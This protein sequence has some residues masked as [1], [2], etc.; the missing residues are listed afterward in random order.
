MSIIGDYRVR[1]YY[2]CGGLVCVMMLRYVITVWVSVHYSE[3]DKTVLM[4]LSAVHCHSN[5]DSKFKVY[6]RLGVRGLLHEGKCPKNVN[7]LVLQSCKTC[8][9]PYQ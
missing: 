8:N 1:V 7:I 9:T 3:A 4:R 6:P 2:R 5:F